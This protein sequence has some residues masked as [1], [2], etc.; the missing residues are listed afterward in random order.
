[1]KLVRSQQ[2]RVRSL[3]HSLI[4]CI[5]ENEVDAIQN[6]LSHKPNI[7]AFRNCGASIN[8]LRHAI[9]IKNVEMVRVLLQLGADV[10]PV[11][12]ES[13]SPLHLAIA[14]NNA[15]IVEHI[16]NADTDKKI[17]INCAIFYACE[18]GK[19]N[20]LS[21]L[22]KKCSDIN[23]QDVKGNTFLHRAV[24]HG[25]FD[26]VEI[27]LKYG[28]DCNITNFSGCIPLELN[29]IKRHKNKEK[30][31]EILLRFSK[32][33]LKPSEAPVV[34]KN[35]RKASFINAK[36]KH[37]TSVM[38]GHSFVTPKTESMRKISVAE[39]IHN[40]EN[41]GKNLQRLNKNI[42]LQNSNSSKDLQDKKL[43]KDQKSK[44]TSS[45]WLIFFKKPSSGLRRTFLC[46]FYC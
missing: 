1:M 38:G 11:V 40:N 19:A 31:K 23:A 20:I 26:V 44:A 7:D 4:E 42:I 24:S 41:F 25:Y 37:F 10:S 36:E 22:I 17:D 6:M 33:S 21:L 3:S 46:C 43:V 14:Q 35:E 12:E 13:K 9:S 2:S 34:K 30:I 32:A 27:L 39:H 8:P 16:L 15:E 45:P 29:E 5:D 18:N 28:A